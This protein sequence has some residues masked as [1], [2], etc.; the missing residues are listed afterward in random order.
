MARTAHLGL[1]LLAPAQAQKHVTVNEALVR[2]DA[3]AQLSVISSI[4]DA[5]PAEATDGASYLLPTGAGGAWDGK[6]DQ[7]AVWSNG[8]WAYLVPKAGWR[9]W[10]EGRGGVLVFDGSAWV[11]D[12][13]AVSPSGAAMLWKV[14]EFDHVIAPGTS[15]ATLTKVPNQAQVIGI[16]GRVLS[17][18]SGTDLTGW[19]IGVSGSENRYGA[20]LG[21]ERNSFLVGLSGSPVTYYADTPLVLSAEGGTFASGTLRLAMNL[22]QLS[23]P[24]SV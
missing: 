21:L 17:T 18:I 16:T 23:P 5:P 7:I 3:A 20:G 8:G 15:N 22:L 13:V 10:D 12:A 2:L 4:L 19:R 24:R 6:A 11:A 1:P 14:V 9:T